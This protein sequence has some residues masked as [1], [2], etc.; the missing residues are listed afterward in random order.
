M[1]AYGWFIKDML[2]NRLADRSFK[3]FTIPQRWTNGSIKI[4]FKLSRRD[5]NFLLNVSRTIHTH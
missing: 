1:L 2:E 3:L 4:S 5:C